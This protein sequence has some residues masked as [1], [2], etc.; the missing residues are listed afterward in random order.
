[1]VNIL[2]EEWKTIVENYKV[3]NF[4]NCRKDDKVI[5]CSINNRGYKYFQLQREGKRINYL[6]HQEVAKLFIGERPNKFDTDHIDR[7]KL[8]NN[9]YNL[10]YITHK[11]NGRNTDRYREDILETD[12]ILRKKIFSAE[13]NKKICQNIRRKKGTGSIQYRNGKYRA[14]WEHKYIAFDTKEKAEEYLQQIIKI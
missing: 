13:Y 2:M 10:R 7:N 11:E 9:V 4:G 1:M 14:I 3:S 6:I 12:L 8:N 5:N